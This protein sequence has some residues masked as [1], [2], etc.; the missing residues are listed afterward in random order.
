M[1]AKFTPIEMLDKLISFDTV[2]R[3]SNLPIIDFIKN[4]L[5]SYGVESHLVFNGDKTKSN[6]YANIGPSKPGG[7]ILSGH[8]DVV[9]IDGQNWNSNPFKIKETNGKIYGRGTCDMKGFIAICL[10]LVP[11]MINAKLNKP[12]QL[13]LS[14]DEEVGC[15]GAPFMIRE[16]KKNLPKA[17]CA[18]VGEPTL[19]KLVDGHKASIGLDTEVTGFE[20][21]SSLLPSG[22]S[23]IMTASKL[24]NWITDKTE[25]N[26]N[27]TPRDLDKLFNPPFTT[28]H[29]GKIIGGTASNITAKKCSFTTDIRC[30]PLDDGEKI[31]KD[32]EKY[33]EKIST[34][35]KEIRPESNITI[36]RHHWVPGLKPENDGLA[37]SLV[38][39]LTGDNS[40]GKVSYGTEAG[41]FQE[42][43]YSTVICGPGSIEQAHQENE[44][45][46]REQLEKGTQFIMSIINEQA[47]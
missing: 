38:R 1:S 44:F 7:V 40:T 10:A 2:S 37:E 29:V 12:I 47:N 35:I 24:I 23:A 15:V 36:N 17:S 14:Y 21:H 32:Y 41:Q 18:I 46:S 4:Y 13:A 39:K 16:M 8:T 20:V 22:V 3:N 28:L 26:Q 43:G 31:I 27:K 30:L 25:K 6:L 33:A 9:P 34:K 5:Q 19:L 42:E 45:L 11:E